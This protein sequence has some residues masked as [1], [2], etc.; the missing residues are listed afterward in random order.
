MKYLFF[1]QFSNV[2]TKFFVELRFRNQDN[3]DDKLSLI[4]G[5]YR[6]KVPNILDIFWEILFIIN[7]C[8]Y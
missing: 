4:M 7:V 8:T 5:Q 3:R 1:F 6:V 2:C